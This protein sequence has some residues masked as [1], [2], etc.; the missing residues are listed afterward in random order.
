M[1]RELPQ[2]IDMVQ[3]HGEDF[4]I[5]RRLLSLHHLFKQYIQLETIDLMLDLDFPGADDT[6]IQLVGGIFTRCQGG[7]R[8]LFRAAIQPQKC[9]GYP[10]ATSWRPT[11][12]EALW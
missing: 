2:D 1:Q 7:G 3:F 4:E 11:E 6:E 10:A 9:M 8:E 5:I 12:P